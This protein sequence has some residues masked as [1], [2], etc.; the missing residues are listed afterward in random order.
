V[1]VSASGV[2]TVNGRWLRRVRRQ[3]TG[4]GTYSL[5][6]ALASQGRRA[7]ARRHTLKVKVSI[8]YQPNGAQISSTTAWVTFARRRR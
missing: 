1:T 2:I 5:R 3:V 8:G 7:L 6:V 4:A